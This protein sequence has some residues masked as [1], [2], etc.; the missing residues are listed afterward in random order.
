M[1]DRLPR[2]TDHG[3]VPSRRSFLKRLGVGAFG[4]ALGLPHLAWRDFRPMRI[5]RIEVFPILYPMV[6]RF[7][8]FEGPEGSPTGR[9]AAVVKITAEDGTIGWG[10][11]LP[12]PKWSYETRESVTSTI[13]SYLAP[14]LI[15][16]NAFDIVGAHA[17]MDRNI[18]AGSS[19][20]A[21]MAKAGVDIA[22]HD[23]A[24]KLMNVSLAQLWGRPEGGR[25]T[26]SWT[27]NPVKLED[28]DALIDEG[29]KRGYRNF[30]VKVSPD[31]KFDIE[32]CRRVKQRVPGGFLWADA[33]GGY[34]LPTA[35]AVALVPASLIGS[36]NAMIRVAAIVAGSTLAVLVAARREQRERRACVPRRAKRRVHHEVAEDQRHPEQVG[37][38]VLARERGHLGRRAHRAD[39]LAEPDG[40]GDGERPSAGP[41]PPTEDDA[42]TD[43]RCAGE[44]QQPGE[45]DRVGMPAAPQRR[46]HGDAVMRQLHAQHASSTSAG[47]PTI[48][49]VTRASSDSRKPTNEIG[50]WSTS[51]SD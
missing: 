25:I 22:L 47:S 10:E 45:H 7:K 41:G 49:T 26:L 20:G 36:T 48:S 51:R 28:L 17:I 44:Q 15:G 16:H 11:S 30:N 5:A 1:P 23:L 19:T 24:G 43:Q 21:P 32:L 18:A 33:N 35:L 14:E 4:A 40:A 39:Q 37:A 8:F 9:S 3:L 27:C 31:P 46:G 50:S 13:R 6:G 34:D 12:I 29:L 38:Q 2:A 42:R